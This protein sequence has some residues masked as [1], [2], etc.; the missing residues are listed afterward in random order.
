[1]KRTSKGSFPWQV[2]K[3]GKENFSFLSFQE[4]W[5]WNFKN[6]QLAFISRVALT[7]LLLVID[8]MPH[9]FDNESESQW[10]YMWV[11]EWMSIEIGMCVWEIS[12]WVFESNLNSLELFSN[13]SQLLLLLHRFSVF[14]KIGFG[15]EPRDLRY[16]RDLRDGKAYG[17][18]INNMSNMMFELFRP[19]FLLSV[20]CA[21][22]KLSAANCKGKV[23]IIIK[24]YNVPYT[25]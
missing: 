16:L 18:S 22:A 3:C 5:R 19:R 13:R 10:E 14:K 9:T 25:L 20:V 11:W 2:E 1:M 7:K 12:L 21:W 6:S 8:W 15:R 4:K 17:Q 24:R 23:H